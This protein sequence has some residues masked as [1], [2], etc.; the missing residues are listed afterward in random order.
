MIPMLSARPGH[1]GTAH[2]Q[3]RRFS[4]CAPAQH[5]RVGQALASYVEL[6]GIFRGCRVLVFETFADG[7]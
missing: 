2:V 6:S 1:G 5:V 7:C 3:A 4:A